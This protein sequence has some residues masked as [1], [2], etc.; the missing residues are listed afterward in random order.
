VSA[1]RNDDATVT[2]TWQADADFESGLQQFIILL[3][4]KELRQFPE[5]PANRFGRPL[6]QGMSN[7]DTPTEP[8]AE[9]KIVFPKGD[10]S[11]GTRLQVISVNSVQLRSSP[12]SAADVP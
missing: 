7:H 11:A 6:F 3:D 5:K 1:V 4:G 9:M 2:L 8:L 10:I 12:S